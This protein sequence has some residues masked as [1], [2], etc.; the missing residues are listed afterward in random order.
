VHLHVCV[1]RRSASGTASRHLCKTLL[2]TLGLRACACRRRRQAV[3][4]Q[5]H[6]RTL[7][8]VSL[9][10]SRLVPDVMPAV[11]AVLET[12]VRRDVASAPL[13]MR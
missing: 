11:L 2:I 8:R 4:V 6:A 7:V 13:L 3:G 9:S 5:A 10:V 12:D 1:R